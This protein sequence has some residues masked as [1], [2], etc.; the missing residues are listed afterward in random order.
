MIIAVFGGLGKVCKEFL[1]QALAHEHTLHWFL[2]E[3]DSLPDLPALPILKIICGSPNNIL[4]YQE[5]I[6]GTDAVLVAFDPHNTEPTHGSM[7][8]ENVRRLIVVT[9]HGSGD[10]RRQMDWTT[11]MYMNLNQIKYL[12]GA[13][14]RCWSILA[15]YTAQEHV[16]MRGR[17]RRTC[18]EAVRM[19]R[20]SKRDASTEAQGTLEWTILRPGLFVEG[21]ATGTYL[22]SSEDVFGGYV[23]PADVANCAL[24]A[25]E[26]GMDKGKCF[27]VAYSSRV[28]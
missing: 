22:A 1:L 25:L 14:D 5:A 13:L 23:S 19:G 16:V 20:R 9:C 18:W 7:H 27:S 8:R 4:H 12:A 24:K 15:Q 28:A 17:F 26:D 21:I 11:W 6:Q 3:T 10:S 2:Q